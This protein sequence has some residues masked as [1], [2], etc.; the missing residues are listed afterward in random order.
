MLRQ[1]Q[2]QFSVSA[3]LGRPDFDE[4]WGQKYSLARGVLAHWHQIGDFQ[5]E[6]FDDGIGK[7]AAVLCLDDEG[8]RPAGNAGAVIV[9]E[10]GH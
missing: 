5:N 2:E 8:P 9:A 10:T 1:I 6:F 4:F 7:G 3:A